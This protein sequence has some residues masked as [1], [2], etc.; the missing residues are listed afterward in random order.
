LKAESLELQDFA[1]KIRRD[2]TAYSDPDRHVIV[3]A[4]YVYKQ[5]EDAVLDTHGK[6]SF[7]DLVEWVAN[8]NGM[9]SSKLLS[10]VQE[11]SNRV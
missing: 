4:Q 3:C 8:D 11:T 1:D 6:R 9:T 5:I 7:E 10:V 2:Y